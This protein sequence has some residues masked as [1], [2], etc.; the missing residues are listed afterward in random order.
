MGSNPLLIHGF[1]SSTADRGRVTFLDFLVGTLTAF[2]PLRPAWHQFIREL[3]R[4]GRGRARRLWCWSSCKPSTLRH[5]AGTGH[6]FKLH[7]SLS[8]PKG[9]ECHPPP[10]GIVGTLGTLPRRH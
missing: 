4:H 7:R 10:A 2:S 5:P 6:G 9:G 1:L 8:N 3:L